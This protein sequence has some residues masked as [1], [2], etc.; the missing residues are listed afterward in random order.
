MK[1]RLRYKKNGNTLIAQVTSRDN[2]T[3]SVK[4]FSNTLSYEIVREP[5]LAI[6]SQ[7]TDTNLTLAKLKAR[8][9]TELQTLN[10]EFNNE[11]RR[12]KDLT[13]KYAG[14]T[15]DS[16]MESSNKTSDEVLDDSIGGDLFF[17][18]E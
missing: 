18:E 15:F 13:N 2:F 6:V 9:K 7:F 10:V 14:S 17:D 4:I 5:A 8:V 1:T 16:F 3:Y 12:K 11:V